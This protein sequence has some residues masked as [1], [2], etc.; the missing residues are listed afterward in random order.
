MRSLVVTGDDFGFSREVNRAIVEAYERGVLTCASLMINGDAAAEAVAL[1]RSHPGL[2]VGLHLVVVDGKATLPP[3]KIP[4]L[5]DHSG[6]FRGGPLRVGL[7][8]QFSRDARRQLTQEIRAQIDRFRETGLSLSHVDGHHHLH[9]HPVVLAA[10]VTLSARG[11]HSGDPASRGGARPGAGARPI[12]GGPQDSL[13]RD[14]RVLEKA[15]RAGAGRRGDSVFR[16]RLRTP[17]DGSDHGE[18]SPP[19]DPADPG[20]SGRALL[21]S[22]DIRSRPPVS[23]SAGVGPGGVRGF[24]ERPGSRR[25][26][27][28]P[29]RA[30]RTPCIAT[31]GSSS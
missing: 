1:A 16:A 20:R 10:L 30:G 31:G 15:R 18:L 11:S 12:G 24:D 28:E 4:R 6:K 21:P 14:F 13:E 19:T 8:Y 29:L 22:G 25:A 3:A 2:A 27:P 9:L 26:G 7:R 17:R 5:V 23:G